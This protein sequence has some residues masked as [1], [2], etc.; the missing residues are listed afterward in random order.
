MKTRISCETC[1]QPATAEREVRTRPDGKWLHYDCPN[2]HRFH[3][4]ISGNPV[5]F[6]DCDC[7]P[8]GPKAK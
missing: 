6:T 5:S 3:R 1:G 4:S 7:D 8:R 2:G